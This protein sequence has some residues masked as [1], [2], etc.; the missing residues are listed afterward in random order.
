M[1]NLGGL[2]QA[3][4]ETCRSLSCGRPAMTP[5]GDPVAALVYST[6]AARVESLLVNGRWLMRKRELLTID[7]QKILHEAKSLAES[8]NQA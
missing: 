4:A 3:A 6:D 5:L 7:E 1:P 8:L 2:R